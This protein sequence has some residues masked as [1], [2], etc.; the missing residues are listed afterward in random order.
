M[1]DS[2]TSV[3][4]LWD[5]IHNSLSTRISRASDGEFHEMTHLH[6]V[7]IVDDY[8]TPVNMPDTIQINTDFAR[9]LY[10]NAIYRLWNGEELRSFIESEFG[11]EV[12]W[13]FDCLRPY[14]Y[15]ADLARF[16]LLYVLGGMYL[17]LGIRL[18][19]RWSIPRRYQVA[20]CRDVAFLTANWAT[21]QTGLLWSKPRQLEFQRAID[22]II[23]NCRSQYYGQSPLHPTGP[24]LLGKTM[25]TAL[26]ERGGNAKDSQWIGLCRPIT[27]DSG[28]WNVCYISRDER[29]IALRTKMIPGD[30]SHLGIVGG[31]NYN[32]IWR[33]HRA[34]GERVFLW[35]FCDF[36]NVRENLARD[37]EGL[38]IQG[39]MSGVVSWGPYITLADGA[40]EA[41]FTFSSDTVASRVDLD[42]C[43]NFGNKAIADRII[44]DPFA[45][46][47]TELSLPFDL[48]EEHDNVECRLKV[49]DDFVG[50]IKSLVI[51]P[52]Q[53]RRWMHSHPRLCVARGT[54]TDDG[55]KLSKDVDGM[56]SFGP[57]VTVLEGNYALE[58]M[59]GEVS[60]DSGQ[61]AIDICSDHGNR[62]LAPIFREDAHMLAHKTEIVEFT[63]ARDAKNVEFRTYS[64]GGV[65]V[66]ILG[67]VL[68]CTSEDNDAL[69][70]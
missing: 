8:G 29:M 12:L 25:I 16:C 50:T 27:P 45:D 43:S 9:S 54:K 10:P 42:V 67:F 18:L 66:E 7:I 63:C 15:K 57:Y 47:R 26:V 44:K 23:E 14:S 52:R 70:G 58:I 49:F 5:R 38:H 40:Y 22:F 64:S 62:L 36:P 59:F 61:V 28:M 31:N 30:L 11:R 68:I 20:A 65:D 55:I 2:Q 35:T 33:S 3:R 32:W 48:D 4:T 17:D 60:S 39:G 51:R 1:N 53:Q 24:V 13:A 21:M 19:S 41:T 69:A 56:I 46:A 6:Q 37:E 34:Y